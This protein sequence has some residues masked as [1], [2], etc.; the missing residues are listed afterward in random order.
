MITT[1]AIFEENSIKIGKYT[2]TSHV[3]DLGDCFWKIFKKGD[4]VESTFRLE[5]AIQYCVEKR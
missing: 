4:L 3:T 1:E 5:T 2:L